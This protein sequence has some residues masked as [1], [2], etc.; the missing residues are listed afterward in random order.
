[1]QKLSWSPLTKPAEEAVRQFVCRTGGGSGRLYGG[2]FRR[3]DSMS[4]MPQMS[5]T[6]S[7][8]NQISPESP[9]R[10]TRTNGVWSGQFCWQHSGAGIARYIIADN[11]MTGG[12]SQVVVNLL[13]S[14]PP[15]PMCSVC[16]CPF[17][18]SLQGFAAARI[19][20]A[21]FPYYAL[22]P[23]TSFA[24]GSSSLSP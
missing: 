22:F 19:E 16:S 24:V 9:Q 23:T 4:Q 17:C 15:Y 12:A 5:P 21:S 2:A 8:I 11:A 14:S 7:R 1:M 18:P 6:I 10:S 20:R 3:W 13:K